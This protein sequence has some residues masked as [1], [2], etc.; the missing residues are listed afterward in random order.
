MLERIRWYSRTHRP[1]RDESALLAPLAAPLALLLTLSFAF[2][3][4]VE[5]LAGAGQVYVRMPASMPAPIAQRLLSALEA[6]L[7]D[8][9]PIDLREPNADR[10]LCVVLVTEVEGGLSIQ[11]ANAR[12]QALSAPRFVP[13]A[14]D[15]LSASQVASIVRAFVV[16]RLD[17]DHAIALAAARS[18]S[19]RVNAVHATQQHDAQER[20]PQAHGAE[21]DPQP[22]KREPEP[23]QAAAALLAPPPAPAAAAGAQSLP[24]PESSGGRRPVAVDRMAADDADAWRLRLAALYSGVN[25]APELPWQDGL[26][27]EASARVQ[28]WLYLGAGYGYQLPEEVTREAVQI[29]IHA[30]SVNAF[31]GLGRTWRRF[32]AGLDAGLGAV[33]TSRTTQVDVDA[34]DGTP[35]F[36]YWSPVGTLRLHGR[37]RFPALPR[38]ALDLAPALE[39][40]GG[41]RQAVVEAE[42]IGETSVL[43]PRSVRARVDVGAAFDVF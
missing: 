28:R 8:L 25:Y 35:G 22:V 26:R 21:R 9:A 13:G 31:L 6:Q 15:E 12:A 7:G 40:V 19:D 18:E 2:P 37:L 36:T 24:L 30:H 42:I 41:T 17:G 14:A 43:S 27:V 4:A 33:Q 29:R 16:A 32:G 20:A 23:S 10:A 39:L 5:A 1:G 38:L 11:L 34:L 3:S